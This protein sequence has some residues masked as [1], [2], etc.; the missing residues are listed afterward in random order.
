MLASGK[1]PELVV[2][3]AGS[4][5][6]RPFAISR[7]EVSATDFAEFC[8]QSGKCGASHAQ[9]DLPQT[10]VPVTEAVQYAEWLSAATG[11]VYRLPTDTEWSY[12]ASAP[13]GSTERDYNC[14]VEINGQK[15]RGLA[16]GSVRSGKP[17]G[18]GLFNLVGNAQEWVKTVDGWSARG[19]AYN[20]PISQC[21]VTAA[22]ATSG[23]AA[24]NTGFRVLR[25]LK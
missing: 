11:S 7:F 25:E 8:R 24:D 3:P 17:N 12:A 16:L 1:G 20:D 9:S 13:A 4:G 6:A 2:V 23:S 18:W 15:I 22:R 19:G 21:S 14:V 10:G 5:S